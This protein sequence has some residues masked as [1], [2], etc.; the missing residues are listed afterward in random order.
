[1]TAPTSPRIVPTR[2]IPGDYDAWTF[3][4]WIFTRKG[5]AVGSA[6]LLHETVHWERQRAAGRWTWLWKYLTDQDFRYAEELAGHIAQV[7]A[8][9]LTIG[10]AA[11]LLTT[12][13][14]G[15]TYDEAIKELEDGI[16]G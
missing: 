10:R 12:Y 5:G 7:R 11:T 1:V 14:T 13:H 15:R 16:D 8:G 6:L 3:Y 9:G 2:L 4:P